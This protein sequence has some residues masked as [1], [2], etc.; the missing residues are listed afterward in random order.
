MKEQFNRSEVKFIRIDMWLAEV[1][2]IKICM[3]ISCISLL[4]G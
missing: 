3:C 1:D 4:L 2:A